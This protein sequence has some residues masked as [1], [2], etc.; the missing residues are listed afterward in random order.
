MALATW[1]VGKGSTHVLYYND[2][3]YPLTTQIVQQENHLL[4]KPSRL[5]SSVAMARVLKILLAVSL[6]LNGIMV[7]SVFHY[8]AT[9][10]VEGKHGTSPSRSLHQRLAGRAVDMDLLKSH[11]ITFVGGV[12]R[13]GTTLLRAMLDAHPDI[14][15]GEETRVI[16]R[17]ISMR[18]KWM[19][20]EKEHRRLQE[21]GLN[22]TILDHATRQFISNI[23]TANGPSAPH[24]C[25][26][27]PLVLNYMPDIVRLYSKAKFILMVRDG[28][29]VAHSIV[30]HN[31]TITGV[32]SKS[33]VS[34]ALFW[35]KVVMRMT[36]DCRYL[37]RHRCM[38]VHY[39]ELVAEPRQWMEQI[40]EFL[41]IPWHD[42]VLKHHKFINS[43]ISISK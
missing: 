16:P 1:S 32:D 9:N 37:G 33:Y 40:L 38:Q 2:D 13:S 30:S 36:T 42:N 15:C 31:V 8:N 22:D 5:L 34:A 23:I 11:P 12:P 27:D 35:N 7:I 14:R 28:R 17:I 26:K 21:A 24:L 41:E 20:S 4:G 18:S 39:E 10:R 25:N 29:A 19:K 3:P 43:E 6:V